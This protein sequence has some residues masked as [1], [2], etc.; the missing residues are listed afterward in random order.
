[1]VYS[2]I[3]LFE[4][5]IFQLL[6]VHKVKIFFSWRVPHLLSFYAP[7]KEIGNGKSVFVIVL[8]KIPIENLLMI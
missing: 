5:L 7:I 4:K 2:F 8:N 6:W 3:E 1:M